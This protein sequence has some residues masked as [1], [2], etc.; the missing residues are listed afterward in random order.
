MMKVRWLDILTGVG[1]FDANSRDGDGSDLYCNSWGWRVDVS[2]TDRDR[3][4]KQCN[5]KKFTSVM[6]ISLYLNSWQM[7]QHV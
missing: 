1:E 5:I 4:V 2:V 6:E 7:Y 3:P